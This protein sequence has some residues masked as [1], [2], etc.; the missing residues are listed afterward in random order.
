MSQ[1]QFQL[2][3]ERRFLPFFLTQSSGAFNDN[4]FKQAVVVLVGY[5]TPGITSSQIDLYSNLAAALL[6]APFFLFSATAGQLA[7]KLDKAAM[8][9]WVKFGEILIMAIAGLG[10]LTGNLVVLMLAVFLMGTQSTLFGPIKY[11]ILPQVLDGR[12]LVGGNGLVEMGTFLAILLGTIVGTYLMHQ[13]GAVVITAAVLGVALFGWLVAL[14]IP[15]LPALA[16]ELK[17]DWNVLRATWRSL[18]DLKRERAIFL[19]CLGISWFWFYGSIYF[20]QLLNYARSVLGGDY[21]VYTL[22]LAIFSVG[23]AVGSLLCE[24]LSAR[25]VEIGLVP[26]GSLGMTV[27]GL[28]LYFAWPEARGALERPLTQF[29]SEPAAWRVGFDL[30]AMSVFGGFFIVPL[31]AM[32]QSRAAPAMRSRIIA[33]NNILNALFMVAASVA[34]VLLLKGVGLSIPELFALTALVNVLVAV[35]IYTLVPEFTLRFFTWLLI[36][37]LYRIRVEGLERIP[38]SGPV[39]LVCNHVSYVDALLI[40]GSVLR[41]TRFVMY[42][43]IYR[44]PV[45]N[46]LFRAARTIPIAGAKE[47]PELLERAFAEI[48]RALEAGEVVCIFPEGG[49]TWN[50]EIAPFKKGVERILATHPVPVIPMALQGLWGSFFSRWH[51]A[52]GKWRWPRRFWSRVGLVIGTPRDGRSVDAAGLEV[53][54]R[55]LRGAWA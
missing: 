52:E 34:A 50:G 30:F 47:D 55:A 39:L 36:N 43:K 12:E 48:A 28:D 32:V 27:F 8:A 16:P 37:T 9:R 54:V 20:I 22:L 11:G 45:L 1:N 24:K 4:L 51:G 15:A 29:L 10:F 41:P 6:I 42:Y 2:L 53:E 46:Y 3:T 18:A 44:L 23:T 49:L 35:Y 19:S 26:F 31:Y 38:E 5:L 17:V 21:Q 7:D 13:H 14:K 33:G 25:R 40:G